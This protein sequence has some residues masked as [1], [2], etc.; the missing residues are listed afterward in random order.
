MGPI[1]V[2]W[3]GRHRDANLVAYKSLFAIMSKTCTACGV[4][5]VELDPPVPPKGEG[6]AMPLPDV[7]VPVPPKGEGSAMPHETSEK[8]PNCGKEGTME[9]VA[10]VSTGEEEQE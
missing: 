7:D 3:R 9:E 2:V 4:T 5:Q 10:E 6:S 8:C 1:S